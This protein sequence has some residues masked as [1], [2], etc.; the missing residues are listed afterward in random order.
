MKKENKILCTIADRRYSPYLYRWIYSARNAGWRGRIVVL[1]N[2]ETL[3]ANS[4]MVLTDQEFR[5]T[6]F[7]DNR[8]IKLDLDKYFN[9]GDRV[10][11]FDV[12]IVFFPSMPFDELFK[13]DLSLTTVPLHH[14]VT[15]EMPLIKEL[16][17]IEPYTKYLAS[18]CGFLKCD[19][20]VEFFNHWRSYRELS[21]QH[22]KG[23]MFALNLACYNRCMDDVFL[24][25]ENR[26]AYT[27]TVKFKEKVKDPYLF[28]YGGAYGK[29]IWMNEYMK[30]IEYNYRG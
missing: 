8:W 2:D 25:P 23:T 6:V 17:G 14:D 29:Q 9:E 28:H 26:C 4:E 22:R 27:L 7:K 13:H 10:V 3:R 11:F 5:T 16:T 1:T 15:K 12:D 18:P 30:G 21:K 19:E 20:T 24:L